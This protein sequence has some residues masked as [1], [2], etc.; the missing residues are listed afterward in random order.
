MTD[1]LDDFEGAIAIVGMA[2]R[3]PGARDVA[4]LW[5][6]LRAGVESVRFLSREE[7]AALGA[8]RA[9][10]DPA[11][12]PAVAMPDGID[13]FD[14]PFFGIS[15]REAEILDPQHR[16]FL[17]ACWTALED[18]GYDP[19]SPAAVTAVFGGATTS[20]YLLFNL[21]RN[22]QVAAT[23]DPLQLIVGNAVD[24]LTTRVSYKLNLKGASQA[25]QCACST[26]LVAVH[27]ACQALLNQECDVAL[28]GG[29]S[30]NVG[31]RAGYRFQEDSILAPDGH[32]RAFD[33]EARGTVFGGGAGVVVL[34]RL[35]DAV[36]DRDTV[37]AVIRG[38]A[39]NNDGGI[40]VGYTAPSVEGQAKVIAEA[41][42]VAGI[43]AG[44]IG[45][46]E[47]HGTGTA[48]G[49]PIEIQALAKAFRARTPKRGFAA[50]GT[51]KANIGHLD[52]AAGIAG[53]IKTVLALQHGEIPPSLHFERP[54]PRIDFAAGPVY[55]NRELA[56][57]KRDGTPRRAGVSSFGFG[58]T[59][60]H[61]ILEEA[62]APPALPERPAAAGPWRLLA[63]SAKTPEALAAAVRNLAEFLGE[64]PETDLGDA[65]FTLIAGRQA[66]PHRLAAVCR[67][68]ADAAACLAGAA[69]ALDRGESGEYA[70]LAAAGRRWLAGEPLEAAE[71]F[72]GQRRR[73]IPLPTYPFERHRYWIE[74]GGI[75]PGGIEPLAAAAPAQ[76]LHAR[77][78]LATAFVAPRG[79]GEER[80][81]AVWREVLG[82]AEV[83]VHDSFLELG[84]DSLLATRLMARLRE[85]LGVDLAMD[86]LFEQPTVAA[87]AAAV[88]EARAVGAGADD[89]ARL[90]AEIGSLSEEELEGELRG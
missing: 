18:A 72:A 10:D 40:K 70:Q 46:I 31:Q 87:V 20:T 19:E 13:E 65:A 51:V 66:F 16:L 80:V 33:A 59:N 15:H 22:P 5:R 45:Y 25:V 69:P 44:T 36:R 2:G 53:L 8:G 49:D 42:S 58:G 63:V 78:P 28:A 71:L 17:E 37:R 86:R 1:E 47:G 75:E 82:L 24:S 62:P 12:V 43:D 79:E 27:L 4:E 55:V 76:T 83:G 73:R 64:N 7:M 11:W 3:F 54:N 21:A 32:C 38:S 90:L 52:I 60:A 48:L 81:A 77:P 14:A 74:P 50:L 26:S 35:E 34:K 29:V 39:V 6:N 89:L 67:D 30:I 85:E 41:L 23:V 68:A 56:E 9:A 84:G 61:V 88:V 57:W